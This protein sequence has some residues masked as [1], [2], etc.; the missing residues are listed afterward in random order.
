MRIVRAEYHDGNILESWVLSH[1]VQRL[2]AIE[3]RHDDIEQHEI[4][5]PVFVE[6]LQ[7]LLPIFGFEC[8]VDVG[9]FFEHVFKKFS[10]DEIVVYIENF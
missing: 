2:Y 8:F 10:I 7:G 3:A 5:I 9:I 6:D 4:D 1:V